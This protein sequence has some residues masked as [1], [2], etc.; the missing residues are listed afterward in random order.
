[1]ATGLRSPG[2]GKRSEGIAATLPH[3]RPNNLLP[4]G[5]G[6]EGPFRSY[7]GERS[8]CAADFGCQKC[9]WPAVRLAGRLRPRERDDW[10]CVPPQ[11]IRGQESL[12][13]QQQF[14]PLLLSFPSTALEIT[15][16][17]RSLKAIQIGLELPASQF[18][19]MRWFHQG[20][21][22]PGHSLADRQPNGGE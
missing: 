1:V 4:V 6:V 2:V 19:Q 22:H 14:G 7:C 9:R 20:G 10:R 5:S 17:K 16:N 15:F 13:A 18:P 11:A 8:V 3:W 12:A 21:K